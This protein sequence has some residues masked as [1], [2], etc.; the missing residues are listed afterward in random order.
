M[1]LGSGLIRTDTDMAEFRDLMQLF[2]FS[3]HRVPSLVKTD[4]AYIQEILSTTPIIVFKAPVC[5]VTHAILPMSISLN[6]T[7]DLF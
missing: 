7:A 4:D 1:D 5:T 2:Y 6:R 3:V